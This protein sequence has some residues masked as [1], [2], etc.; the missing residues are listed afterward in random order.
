[1]RKG[2]GCGKP[3]RE[4]GGGGKAEAGVKLHFAR[5]LWRTLPPSAH[6][7][8]RG[9][10]DVCRGRFRGRSLAA[11]WHWCATPLV[12]RRDC[13]AKGYLSASVALDVADVRPASVR[14]ERRGRTS[15]ERAGFSAGTG[16]AR[17]LPR[18]RAGTVCGRSRHRWS[19]AGS[20]PRRSNGT[21]RVSG[22]WAWNRLRA[23]V[24]PRPAALSLSRSSRDRRFRRCWRGAI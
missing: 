16:D 23:W 12:C 2:G 21:A 15:V 6:G 13:P 7:R 24:R 17:A 10:Y 18:P 20:E 8:G 3:K 5:P 11:V 9:R 19:L 4:Q 22:K 14:A 1:M